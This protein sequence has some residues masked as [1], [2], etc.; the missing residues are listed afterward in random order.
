MAFQKWGSYH[1]LETGLSVSVNPL[2]HVEESKSVSLCAV[3]LRYFN[4]CEENTMSFFGSEP[5]TSATA[6]FIPPFAGD[7]PA[8]HPI[9]E[10]TIVVTVHGDARK[11][12]FGFQLK[13]KLDTTGQ[14]LVEVDSLGWTGPLAEGTV[15]YT[16]K[17]SFHS[18]YVAHITVKGSNHS[19][20]VPVT[21][22]LSAAPNT[23]QE[24]FA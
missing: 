3:T 24:A 19:I 17:G 9:L 13:D 4:L 14:H 5:V 22:V 2:R 15:P 11:F 21:R 16:V 6:V 20:K 18:N 7:Q 8:V 12:S 1:T 10:G 23:A